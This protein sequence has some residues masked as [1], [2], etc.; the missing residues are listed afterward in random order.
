M[1]DKT[2][3]EI[4]MKCSNGFCFDTNSYRKS[5]GKVKQLICKLPSR[6]SN[7]VF[8]VTLIYNDELKNGFAWYTLT[9]IFITGKTK[10][11]LAS[12]QGTSGKTRKDMFKLCALTDKIDRAYL[13]MVLSSNTGTA[14]TAKLYIRL[15]EV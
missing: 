7:A 1:T 13:Q 11:L 14:P 6:Q 10:Q 2:I 4:N 9:I 8:Q 3:K 5:G 12:V 15:L